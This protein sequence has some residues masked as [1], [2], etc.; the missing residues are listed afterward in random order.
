[1]NSLDLIK[2]LVNENGNVDDIIKELNNYKNNSKI[3][4]KINSNNNDL[5]NLRKDNNLKCFN[6][7]NIHFNKI[8]DPY[9]KDLINYDLNDFIYNEK[10][11]SNGD[12]NELLPKLSCFELDSK[13]YNGLNFNDLQF[14][15]PDSFNE[16]KPLDIIQFNNNNVDIGL[17]II[18]IY[19][20][21]LNLIDSC[22]LKLLKYSKSYINDD[23][24][25]N[26]YM[27]VGNDIN[28]DDNGEEIPGQVDVKISTVKDTYGNVYKIKENTTLSQIDEYLNEENVLFPSN[29][30]K[31]LNEIYINHGNYNEIN[32]TNEINNYIKGFLLFN[33]YSINDDN[34]PNLN[35]PHL[36]MIWLNQPILFNYNKLENT[37]KIGNFFNYYGKESKLKFTNDLSDNDLN[38]LCL[39]INS[40]FYKNNFKDLEIN[41]L[42]IF[43]K[44]I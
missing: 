20:S 3:H 19:N 6:N 4:S 18:D 31:S 7:K 26:S 30:S 35:E 9:S 28:L 27:E 32:E 36:T 41:S 23:N 8:K 13:K 11:I 5:I 44:S 15:E 12:L 17:F 22:S 21:D 39:P 10:L 33:S 37:I 29:Q 25:E 38:Q 16:L 2:R 24:D 42:K 34:K 1:M 40:D 14:N 43:E